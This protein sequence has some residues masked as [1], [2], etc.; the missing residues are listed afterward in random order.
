MLQELKGEFVGEQKGKV[1]QSFDR[2]LTEDEKRAL[3]KVIRERLREKQR[4]EE[5]NKKRDEEV[6]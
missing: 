6:V 1:A 2:K 5:L 3:E 4:M